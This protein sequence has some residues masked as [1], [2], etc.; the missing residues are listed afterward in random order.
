[1]KRSCRHGELERYIRFA[2]RGCWQARGVLLVS[3]KVVRQ[4]ECKTGL[5][6]FPE[7][8]RFYSWQAQQEVDL[9]PCQ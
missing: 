7:L 8:V 2:R 4:S 1:M 5:A 3:S 6:L 9:L